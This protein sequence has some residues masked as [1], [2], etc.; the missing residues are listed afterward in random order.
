[1]LSGFDFFGNLV[2]TISGLF[3]NLTFLDS[4][5]SAFGKTTA[6]LLTDYL[7][8]LIVYVVLAIALGLV[9]KLVKIIIEPISDLPFIKVFDRILGLALGIF[10]KLTG[11]V[12]LPGM[13]SFDDEGMRTVVNACVVMTGAFPLVYI[14]S[15][16]LKK[17]LIFF[18][19]LIGINDISAMGLI[20]C[21]ATNVTT[22]SMVDK[23]DKKGIVLNMAFAVSGAFVFAG[24]LAFTVSF[25]ASYLVPV[26][27]GKLTAGICAVV[28]A[29]FVFNKMNKTAKA[30]APAEE[31][32]A[33]KAAA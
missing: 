7:V 14:L 26:I 12:L 17:P 31:K 19:K 11:I 23:M 15:K 25:N 2:T 29:N 30:E 5:A 6:T 4:Y 24:H 27:I 21:L 33:V 28:L 22:I 32:E 18:G 3:K 1:L 16:I 10:S 8:M 20:S 13:A 9:W